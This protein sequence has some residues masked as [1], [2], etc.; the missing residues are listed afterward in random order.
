MSPLSSQA[1][2]GLRLTPNVE[3]APDSHQEANDE[4]DCDER[5]LKHVEASGG[6]QIA[7]LL[8]L[9]ASEGGSWSETGAAEP[10]SQSA[11]P[12]SILATSVSAAGAQAEARVT[13]MRTRQHAGNL[14][15]RRTK[16][17]AEPVGCSQ[18]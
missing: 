8:A 13:L 2:R 3:H 5:R 15:R 14:A 6:E 10:C 4:D 18:T 11:A 1:A 16:R 7:R 9:T 17:Q 12:Y